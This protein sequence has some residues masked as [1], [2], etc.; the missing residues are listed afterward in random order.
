[1]ASG[2]AAGWNWRDAQF[3]QYKLERAAEQYQHMQKIAQS[4]QDYEQEKERVEIVNNEYKKIIADLS[5]RNRRAVERLQSSADQSNRLP[6]TA[7][8]TGGRCNAY[9]ARDSP[10][11]RRAAAELVNVAEQYEK[12]NLELIK[13]RADQKAVRNYMK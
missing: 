5:S 9:D 8:V 3:T 10:Q 11:F 7:A 1:M 4:R 13:C 2:F 6:A 12:I